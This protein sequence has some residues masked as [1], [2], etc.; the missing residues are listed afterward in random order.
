MNTGRYN[1]RTLFST[2]EIEQ[3][4]I[5]E[6]QRDYVWGAENVRGLLDSIIG[7]F[8]NKESLRLELAVRSAQNPG[9]ANSLT[10]EDIVS[11]LSKEYS[12]LKYST[13]IG[14]IYAYHSAEYE[15]R[16]FLIDGQQR[17]TTIFLLLLAAYHLAEKGDEFVKRYCDGGRPKLDYKVREVS[18]DFLIDLIANE[19]TPGC[20]YKDLTERGSYYEVYR[21]DKTASTMMKNYKIMVETIRSRILSEKENYLIAE[22]IEY[23]EDYIEFNYFDTNICEQGEQLYLYMNSRGEGLSDQERIRPILIGRY[24]D[25]LEAGEKWEEWQNFFWQHRNVATHVNADGP[26]EEF[27]HWAAIIHICTRNTDEVTKDLHAPIKRNGKTQTVAQIIEDYIRKEKDEYQQHQQNLW[28]RDYHH[29]VDTFNIEYLDKIFKA[30]QKLIEYDKVNHYEWLHPE[31][32]NHVNRTNEYVALCGAIVYLYYFRSASALDVDR[33]G[34]HLAKNMLNDTASKN[35]DHATIEAINFVNKMFEYKTSDLVAISH[36]PELKS[37]FMTDSDRRC[38]SLCFDS[39]VRSGWDKLFWNLTKSK[40]GNFLK[41][42]YL[43]LAEWSEGNLAKAQCYIEAFEKHIYNELRS[44]PYE[45]YAKLLAFGDFGYQYGWGNGMPRWHMIPYSNDNSH[46]WSYALNCINTVSQIAKN[47]LH[48]FIKPML[49]AKNWP[50]SIVSAIEEKPSYSGH[51]YHLLTNPNDGHHI[52]SYMSQYQLCETIQ[53]DTVHLILGHKYNFS[54]GLYREYMVQWVHHYWGRSWVWEDSTCVMEFSI[55]PL[56]HKWEKLDRG[57]TQHYMDLQYVFNGGKPYWSIKIGHRKLGAEVEP[58]DINVY[59]A[60][61][62]I[63]IENPVFNKII[64]SNVCQLEHVCEDDTKSTIT[65]RVNK[66]LSI[67]ESVLYQIAQENETSKNNNISM[68][69]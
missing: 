6:I 65:Q 36:I 68:A 13:R 51:W 40:L 10:D 45:L 60:L 33:L 31:W 38:I 21:R 56:S 55:D 30:L 39:P 26:F 61:I 69:D 43:F 34:Q 35:P 37:W 59:N 41:G 16:Y 27:L 50:E 9:I 42:D 19:I 20:A 24:Y 18:H 28:L 64:D 52:L 47:Y 8:K 7:H 53:N 48:Q 1:I 25:K 54:E 4:I 12:Q 62:G 17:I 29:A 14:F 46:D 2:T 5:P 3:I 49:S 57:S 22:F 66:I 23:I 44:N 32:Y 63:R 11:F 67:A 15:G 58:L